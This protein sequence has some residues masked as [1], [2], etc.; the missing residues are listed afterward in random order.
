[1]RLRFRRR[2]ALMPPP[3]TLPDYRAEEM[4]TPLEWRAAYVAEDAVD[5]YDADG[6]VTAEGWAWT[7]AEEV[8]AR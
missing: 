8:M 1:M 5:I 6:N 2:P 4:P 3:A 7:V